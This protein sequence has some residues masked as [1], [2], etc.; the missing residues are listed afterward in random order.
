MRGS[1]AKRLRKLNPTKLKS[2][3]K[4][5]KRQWN[6]KSHRQKGAINHG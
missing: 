5:A 2:L 3:Y 1:V 4:A 6:K